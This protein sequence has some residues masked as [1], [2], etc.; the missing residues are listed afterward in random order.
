MWSFEALLVV[1]LTLTPLM[2][3]ITYI[4]FKF[5]RIPNWSV[6]AVFAVFLVVGPWGL[7]I[8]VFLWRLLYA[9][10]VLVLVYGLYSV[11][12]PIVGAGDLKLI[13][14]LVPFVADARLG[15]FLLIYALVA[16]ISLFAFWV[17]RRALRGR[18]TEWEALNQGKFIPV[19]VLLGLSMVIH[20]GADVV[21]RVFL[22]EAV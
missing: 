14:A 1:F 5:L 7:P 15:G 10:V 2:L 9:V 21:G 12:A 22:P 18:E 8:D 20:L 19:G 3:V 11:A 13:S 17:A 16:I 4:D 6:L